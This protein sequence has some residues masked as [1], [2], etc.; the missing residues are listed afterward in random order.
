VE[1][2]QEVGSAQRNLVAVDSQL[3]LWARGHPGNRLRS[4]VS[5]R[6]GLQLRQQSGL[7][8]ESGFGCQLS[9]TRT[10]VSALGGSWFSTLVSPR[11]GGFGY[12]M[13]EA[14]RMETGFGS[15][16]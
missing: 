5:M 14:H 11:I 1:A 7:G 10:G 3:R 12:R 15:G 13:R 4:V 6:F 8:L 9:W 2:A 16:L